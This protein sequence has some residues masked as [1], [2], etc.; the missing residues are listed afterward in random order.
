MKSD[1]ASR[2]RHGFRSPVFKSHT[3]R[4]FG[5]VRKNFPLAIVTIVRYVMGNYFD[6][7]LIL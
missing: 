5:P 4:P 1:L 2:N 3:W 7:R 6:S